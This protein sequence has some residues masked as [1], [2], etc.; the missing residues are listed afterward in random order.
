MP[1]SVVFALT[2]RH[3]SRLAVV[4]F[5]P[6]LLAGLAVYPPPAAAAQDVLEKLTTID[7]F[8]QSGDVERIRV[9]IDE[10]RKLEESGPD[11]E[12]QWRLLRAYGY[13]FSE[14]SC[15]NRDKEQKET[16]KAGY[17]FANRIGAAGSDKAELVYYHADISGR[18]YKDRLLR[19]AWSRVFGGFDPIGSCRNALAMDENIEFAGPHRCLG[20]LYL[21]LPGSKDP[22]KALTHLREA[23]DRFPERVANRYWLA[24]A[25]MRAGRFE[26][27]W[28]Y[29]KGIQERDF[30]VGI[31]VSSE[32]WARIYTGRVKDISPQNIK[33]FAEAG[34]EDGCDELAGAGQDR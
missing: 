10:Y 14:L 27:A 17:E 34:S 3:R 26:E 7:A 21:E 4:L 33:D 1:L 31:G 15:R 24:K 11:P 19:A 30:E 20:V 16:A 32:H 12:I 22:Q 28:T 6:L 29:I 13:L 2:L 23:V 9:S 18:Y 8:A 5:G 25:L